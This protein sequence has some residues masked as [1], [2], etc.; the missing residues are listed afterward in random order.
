MGPRAAKRLAAAP[1]TCKLLRG[2]IV[3]EQLLPEHSV[4]DRGGEA[5]PL[6]AKRLVARRRVF[7]ITGNLLR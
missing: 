3:L 5:G 4:Y 6:A 2:G 1:F 7:S